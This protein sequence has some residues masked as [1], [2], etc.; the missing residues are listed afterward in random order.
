MA[1]PFLGKVFL[2]SAI[3]GRASELARSKANTSKSYKIASGPCLVT[4]SSPNLRRSTRDW[5]ALLR[6]ESKI[7]NPTKLCDDMEMTLM[8][9]WRL[10]PTILAVFVVI[11]GGPKWGGHLEMIVSLDGTIA[12]ALGLSSLVLALAV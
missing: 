6:V 11:A 8:P 3:T 1:E 5:Q 2:P 10:E 12:Y 7:S 9:K 4:V